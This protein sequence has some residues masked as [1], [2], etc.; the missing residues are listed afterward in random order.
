MVFDAE[1]AMKYALTI[2]GKC[3]WHRQHFLSKSELVDS[4]RKWD[5][6]D[7]FVAFR[8]HNLLYNDDHEPYAK[9]VVSYD[10]R[11]IDDFVSDVM[12]LSLTHG[13]LY[14][15]TVGV[16]PNCIG[17]AETPNHQTNIDADVIDAIVDKICNR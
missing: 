1:R 14:I 17:V 16:D 4:I 6:N 11:R 5:F 15:G 9:Q 13:I 12:S 3:F 2:D 7:I 8:L 10:R